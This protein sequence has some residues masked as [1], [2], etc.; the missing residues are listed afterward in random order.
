M[1]FLEAGWA[2]AA[3]KPQAALF[4][5]TNPRFSWKRATEAQRT[6]HFCRVAWKIG[7][8]WRSRW[9]QFCAPHRGQAHETQTARLLLVT[10]ASKSTSPMSVARSAL[11]RAARAEAAPKAVT[12]MPLPSPQV[13]CTSTPTTLGH[14]E[15]IS[16]WLRTAV[17]TAMLATLPLAPAPRASLPV[18]RRHAGARRDHV[19][20]CGE[21]REA[22]PG[23]RTRRAAPA[24]RAQEALRHLWLPGRLG[25]H[26]L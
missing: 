2:S 19:R 21:A 10:L 3:P 9:R 20:L 14:Q 24:W 16:R 5:P 17:T 22:T 23:P 25:R 7:V 4:S 13:A 1:T 6:W 12:T 15:H 18:P 11:A 8:P 26:S